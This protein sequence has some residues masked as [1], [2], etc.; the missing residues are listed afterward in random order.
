MNKVAV[1]TGSSRGIGAATA[2]MLAVEGYAVVINYLTN[3]E[4]ATSVQRDIENKGGR[5]MIVQADVASENDVTCLFQRADE[6]GTLA[7]LVNNAGILDKQTRLTDI[8]AER[9]QRIM[10]TNVL[11]CF[12]CTKE[13]VKRMSTKQ[14]GQGG[15]IVNVSSA[16]AKTGAPN[17]YVDYAASKGAMDSLTRGAALELADEG[18]RVNAVRPGLIETD[19]HRLGGEP[20]RVNRLKGVLPLKRG[21]TTEEV[22]EG[23]VWLASE[24]SAFVTGSLLDIAGGL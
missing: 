19:M 17:E 23:I 16:A 7:V 15:T 5:C 4:A 9:F 24:K 10:Q 6:M 22:A 8:S 11:S 20:D 12:L 14:G 18:I 13:A 1:V 21:G 3:K 2:K